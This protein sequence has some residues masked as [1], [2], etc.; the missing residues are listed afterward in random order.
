MLRLGAGAMRRTEGARRLLRPVT[1]QLRSRPTPPEQLMAGKPE[2]CCQHVQF[3]VH[4]AIQT[5]TI[6][7]EEAEGE[8]GERSYRGKLQTRPATGPRESGQR[9]A[10]EAAPVGHGGAAKL[11]KHG[12]RQCYGVADA[13]QLPKPARNESPANKHLPQRILPPGCYFGQGISS[14]L[15]FIPGKE[16]VKRK[17]TSD[18]CHHACMFDIRGEKWG[19]S[20]RATGSRPQ[21]LS[22]RSPPRMGAVG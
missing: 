17:D 21:K 22:L 16:E 9:A 20:I 5:V 3:S 1:R 2:E 7:P 4:P 19:N 8:L 14:G 6:P 10:L 15:C 12:I 11:V 13:L 18:S